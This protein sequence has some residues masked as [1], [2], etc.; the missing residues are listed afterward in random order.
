MFSSLRSRLWLTYALLI[1]AALGFVFVVLVIYLLRN[2]VLY[3]QNITK[4]KAIE[5]VVLKR[6]DEFLGS[7]ERELERA[8]V[9]ADEN[10]DVRLMLF[11]EKGGVIYDTRAEE[12]E[13]VFPR[14]KALR[15]KI[16]LSDD[17]GKSWL[18][19]LSQLDNGQR[20]LI[21]TPRPNVQ[22]LSV[23]RD[24]L[25]PPFW[26]AGVIALLLSLL[27][28]FVMARWIADPLQR[29]LTATREV[30][31][32]GVN[33]PEKGPQEVRELTQAFNEMVLR[34]QT[35]QQSQREFVAN[36]SHELKTPLTSIQ[37]FAQALLDGAAETPESRRQAAQVIYDES[38]RMHRLALDLL[39]LARFDAGIAEMDFAPVD[40][41]ALLQNSKEKLSLQAIEKGIDLQ[42]N[43]QDMPLMMGDGDRLSQVFTNLID[44]ALKH[45]PAEG[46]IR[47]EA[48]SV[49]S[50]IRVEVVD[51]GMGI[52]ADALP[53][54]FERFYQADPSRR[55]E[56]KS[57]SGLGLA[58]V[59][60]IVLAHG[61][62]ITARSNVN[63]GTSFFI[64]LP[65][66]QTDAT[67]IISRRD[68]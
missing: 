39:D 25:L 63:E 57:S 17:A 21:A 51:T 13:I 40:L 9:R 67:T 53:H 19:S 31:F 37:G 48:G 38:G 2:P 8:L 4:L 45:T 52:S 18:Y 42:I 15:S 61:G 32:Q 34:V 55:A 46:V 66:V 24:E 60:E 20:L 14:V 58:I 22:V 44:N 49:G 29:M 68:A 16:M 62:K 23:L 1:L 26:S 35:A 59:R 5:T 36:V 50:E 33:A 64:T 30:P 28:A 27:L 47:V 11:N 6:Q 54:I 3:R 7:N 10:F 12:S 41:S 43:A 65:L 56:K